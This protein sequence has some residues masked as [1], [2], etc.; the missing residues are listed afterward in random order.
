MLI[1]WQLRSSLVSVSCFH[2]LKAGIFHCWAKKHASTDL[3]GYRIAQIYCFRTDKHGKQTH[4]IQQKTSIRH[5]SQH[6]LTPFSGNLKPSVLISTFSYWHLIFSLLK[7]SILI[8][9]NSSIQTILCVSLLYL[10]FNK[11]NIPS[12]S[13]STSP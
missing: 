3:L 5:N 4:F 8:S 2:S 11:F 9:P 10:I 6:P 12:S 1:L 13:I 7:E